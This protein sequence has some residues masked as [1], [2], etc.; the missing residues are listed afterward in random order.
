MKKLF[1]ILT[2]SIFFT[3]S[4]FC[5]DVC[6]D[7]Q[8]NPDIKFTASYGKLVFDKSKSKEELQKAGEKL[9]QSVSTLDVQI[10]NS[11]ISDI[12]DATQAIAN[13]IETLENDILDTISNNKDYSDEASNNLI[14]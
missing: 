13:D 3:S 10:D 2:L 5:N 12:V 1:F 9:N 7:V 8:I 11:L 6:S 14:L 4:A